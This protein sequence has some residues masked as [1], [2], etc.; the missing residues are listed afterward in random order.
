MSLAEEDVGVSGGVLITAGGRAKEVGT[1]LGDPDADFAGSVKEEEGRVDLKGGRTEVPN[2]VAVSLVSEEVLKAGPSTAESDFKGVK[3]VLFDVD[4]SF[5]AEVRLDMSF[6]VAVIAGAFAGSLFVVT[7]VN[8]N[9]ES[10]AKGDGFAGGS[11]EADNLVTGTVGFVGS[12]TAGLSAPKV[13]WGGLVANVVSA[14]VAADGDGFTSVGV[15]VL[16]S[17]GVEFSGFGKVNV[18]LMGLGVEA[19]GTEGVEV[20]AVVVLGDGTIE[21]N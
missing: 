20:V 2:E 11:G 3:G 13:A 8:L 15:G 1:E 9:P 17:D 16:E 6:A 18:K 7:G 14:G 10:P 21:P 5:G 19:A 12:R 4:T